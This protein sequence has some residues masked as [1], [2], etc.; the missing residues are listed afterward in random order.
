MFEAFFEVFIA[1]FLSIVVIFFVLAGV[2]SLFSSI[3]K[4]GEKVERITEN[5]SN[6]ESENGFSILGGLFAIIGVFI[7]FAML[8]RAGLAIILFFFVAILMML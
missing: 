7:L 2:F 6:G 1:P 3:F 8:A 4:E 5:E